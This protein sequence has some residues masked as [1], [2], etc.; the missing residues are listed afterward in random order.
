MSAAHTLS[1]DSWII[2]VREENGNKKVVLVVND[3]EEIMEF[4]LTSLRF[5]T[6]ATMKKQ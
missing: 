5:W 4:D 2:E 3:G 6:A 1:S